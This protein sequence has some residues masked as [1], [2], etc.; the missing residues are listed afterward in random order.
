MLANLQSAL[1]SD[2]NEVTGPQWRGLG[3]EVRRKVSG[4]SFQLASLELERGKVCHERQRTQ[5]MQDMHSVLTVRSARRA[6]HTR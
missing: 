2:G 5:V 6:W 1:A 4:L 3:I